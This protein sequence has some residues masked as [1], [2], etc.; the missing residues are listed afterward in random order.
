MNVDGAVKKVRVKDMKLMND[1]VETNGQSLR[2]DQILTAFT[3]DLQLQPSPEPS[4]VSDVSTYQLRFIDAPPL[5]AS[6]R[7]WVIFSDLHV[8]SASISVC[9]DVLRSVHEAAVSRKA[10]VIFLGD[11]WHVRGAL[12]VDLLNRVLNEL[13]RWTQ[14]VI[15]IPGPSDVVV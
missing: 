9:E 13:S 12:S 14:P 11:F 3:P 5:H 15:M 7:S 2:S 6:V 1:F 4:V 10:G 8:K